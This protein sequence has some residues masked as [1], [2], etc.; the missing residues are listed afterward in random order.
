MNPKLVVKG[1]N[2]IIE[3]GVSVTDFSVIC[4]LD[5]INAKEL[6]YTLVQN[7][8]GILKPH[9]LPSILALIWRMSLNI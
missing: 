6:L 4:E 2:G 3:G 5:E 1:I 9:Y 7:G 8:I